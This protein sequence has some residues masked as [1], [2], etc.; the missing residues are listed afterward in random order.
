MSR[1]SKVLVS[2]WQLKPCR[3]P[4]GDNFFK[5]GVSG[6]LPCFRREFSQERKTIQVEVYVVK[7]SKHSKERLEWVAQG[8]GADQWVLRCRF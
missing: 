2:L 5:M 6:F 7:Q 1:I 3:T 8:E 4:G